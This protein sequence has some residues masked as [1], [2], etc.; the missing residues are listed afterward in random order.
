[1]GSVKLH[2]SIVSL[3][4]PC[5]NA[6]E[7]VCATIESVLHQKFTEWELILVDDGSRDATWQIISQYGLVDSRILTFRKSNEGTTKTRNYGFSKA[8][9][10]SR[11]IFFLD[12]DDE[13][14][15]NA[16]AQMCTY[17][18]AHSDVGLLA[19]Q[20]QEINAEGCKLG[21]GKR[22]R[23]APGAM[24]P[25]Q[26]RD[27]EVETPFVTFFCATSQGPFAI[28]RRSVYV[29][30]E[31]WET[32]FWP[33][34]DTD[35]FCQMALLSKVHFLPHP[36]YLKRAH[37]GQGM[38]DGTRIQRA[39]SA[40][41]S[42]WDNRQPK[43]GHEAALLEAA[44]RYYY[45]VHKPFRDLK[46]AWLALSKFFATPSFAALRWCIYLLSSA[47]HGFLFGRWKCKS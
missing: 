40:F 8:N 32:A 12:H 2:M 34:E 35:M 22:P 10:L 37:P 30:T 41:R 5:Y 36:L 25:Y 29:Q 4:V 14:G 44:K 46:V 13:L 47:L 15:P 27:D 24:F 21:I 38:N 6:A 19:C 33:H 28:Y 23:W 3:I 18:D 39:Y 43:N 45:S 16:L 11:Y 20:F 1:M 7:Y 26:L 9:L 42:K 17:M 31:G